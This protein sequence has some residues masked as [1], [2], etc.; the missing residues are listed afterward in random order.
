VLAFEIA[1]AEFPFIDAFP[2]GGRG[3]FLP[4]DAG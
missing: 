3:H 2:A 1:V 4:H